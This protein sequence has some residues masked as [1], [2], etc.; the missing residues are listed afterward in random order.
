MDNDLVMHFDMRWQ[1]HRSCRRCLRWRPRHVCPECD[2]EPTTCDTCFHVDGALLCV[3]C[4][5][6]Y[7]EMRQG[8]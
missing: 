1:W 6:R 8:A 5:R 4:E 2:I 3:D 7:E